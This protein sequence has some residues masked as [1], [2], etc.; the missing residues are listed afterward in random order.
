MD[1]DGALDFEDAPA[2]KPMRWRWELRPTGALQLAAPLIAHVGERQE[3]EIYAIT[4][5]GHAGRLRLPSASV[6]TAVAPL[7][8]RRFTYMDYGRLYVADLTGRRKRLAPGEFS[9]PLTSTGDGGVLTVDRESAGP[10]GDYEARIVRIRADGGV[11][12]LL[13]LPDRPPAALGNG[14]GLP[15]FREELLQDFFEA[16][17]FALAA[18]GALVFANTS[19]GVGGPR[20]GLRA[21]VPPDRCDRFRGCREARRIGSEYRAARERL[22]D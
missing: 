15:L 4:P 19:Q 2:G 7:P 12:R 20:R 17:P 3:R 9:E 22:L 10:A 18:D 14:D 6:V 11:E 5:D 8:G 1:I 21:L 13:T 16:G